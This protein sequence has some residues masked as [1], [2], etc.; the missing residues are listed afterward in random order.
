MSGIF[1]CQ[2]CGACCRIEGQVRLTDDDIAR[3]SA[4]LGLSE[5]GFVDQFT[6]LA[7]DRRGLVLKDQVGGACIFLEGGD[8]R[9]NPAKPVQ[10]AG[11]PLN[12]NNPG[13][14]HSCQ[15]VADGTGKST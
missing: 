9:V 10:C 12:W 7:R 15:A 13:W 3:L 8:C 1:Q 11:F 4:F 14:E 5:A 6:Q 2:R